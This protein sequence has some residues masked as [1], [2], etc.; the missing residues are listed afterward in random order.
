MKTIN[1][2]YLNLPFFMG[3]NLLLGLLFCGGCQNKSTPAPDVEAELVLPTLTQKHDKHDAQSDKSDITPVFSLSGT[4][5]SN[6]CPSQYKINS[7]ARNPNPNNHC[8][9]LET[10]SEHA[11]EH[12]PTES[13]QN[14]DCIEQESTSY[15]LDLLF[16]SDQDLEKLSTSRSSNPSHDWDSPQVFSEYKEDLPTEP[17]QNDD[18][19]EQESTSDH[20]NF[21]SVSAQCS[22]ELDEYYDNCIVQITNNPKEA[23]ERGSKSERPKELHCHAIDVNDMSES[24][25]IES[26]CSDTEPVD[27]VT[28]P[29]NFF[30]G[31]DNNNNKKPKK[32]RLAFL[33]WRSQN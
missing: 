24:S 10:L 25:D 32:R 31:L 3:A 1:W 7:I 16:I 22:A 18:C 2:R 6:F 15:H 28:I 29:P 14:D 11:E 23:S 9:S 13:A 5:Q 30:E 8:G 26:V 4:P 20:S 27:S 12:L 17:A 33:P 19:I 21:S